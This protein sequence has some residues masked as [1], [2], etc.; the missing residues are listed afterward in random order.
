M[1]TT[2]AANLDSLHAQ[3]V[4][5]APLLQL[6][7]LRRLQS[8]CIRFQNRGGTSLPYLERSV[9]GLAGLQSLRISFFAL[10]LPDFSF[11]SRLVGLTSLALVGA[12]GMAPP[13]WLSSLTALTKFEANLQLS[14]DN[15]ALLAALPSLAELRAD[16]GHYI[17]WAGGGGDGALPA[18]CTSVAVLR[19]CYAEESGLAS[20]A[21]AF[22]GLREAT[23]IVLVNGR[24]DDDDDDE[25]PAAMSAAPAPWSSLKTLQ[26]ER[27]ETLEERR[28]AV[29]LASL[30]SLLRGAGEL[31]SLELAGGF[32]PFAEDTTSWSS[33]DVAALLAQLPRALESL[34]ISPVAALK[35]AAFTDCPFHP[36][37]VSL[38]LHNPYTDL[39]LTPTASV[40]LK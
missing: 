30:L 18:A 32:D 33:A 19:R 34:T 8:L 35:D 26:L 7:R 21:A 6:G 1:L 20:L 36:A 39:R 23:E 40:S 5:W 13:A 3:D 28:R 2:A 22:P 38:H 31:T 24:G 37:L 17:E 27:F 9:A 16:G 4:A 10:P 15:V 25:D 11:V 12:P 29:A 14:P